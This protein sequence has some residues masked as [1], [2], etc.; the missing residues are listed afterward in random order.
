VFRDLENRKANVQASGAYDEQAV[1]ILDLEKGGAAL[2]TM[3]PKITWP[4]QLQ[5]QGQTTRHVALRTDPLKD[6]FVSLE[7]YDENTVTVT[8]KYFPMQVWVWIGFVVT[9]FGSALAAWPK[10]ARAA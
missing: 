10:K 4:Q 7:G 5:Q 8:I 9:I 1:L 2:T 6:I 3:E